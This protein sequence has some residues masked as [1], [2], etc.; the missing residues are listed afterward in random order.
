MIDLLLQLA[1]VA[2]VLGVIAFCLHLARLVGRTGGGAIA[3]VSWVFS[4]GDKWPQ[5]RR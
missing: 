3:A 5:F 2:L 1:Y 4:G